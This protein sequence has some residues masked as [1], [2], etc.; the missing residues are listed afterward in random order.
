VLILTVYYRY[1]I[2]PEMR[3]SAFTGQI[4][5]LVRPHIDRLG[6]EQNEIGREVAK[7]IAGVLL[8]SRPR[9]EVG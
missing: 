7:R 1:D 6:D 2:F 9:R 5:E 8:Q 4:E 3:S